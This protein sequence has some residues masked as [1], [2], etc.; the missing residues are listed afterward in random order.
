MNRDRQHDFDCVIVGASFAGLACATALARSGAKVAVLEKKSDV[1]IKLHT[2]G[3][4]VK[5][6][7]DKIALLDGLP[8]SYVRRVN[9]VRLYA[10]NLRSV[11]LTAPGYYFLATD[12]PAVLRWLAKQA[13]SAGAKLFCEHPFRG[14]TRLQNGFE[15]T[16]FGTTRFLVGA[17]GPRSHVAGALGLGRSTQYLFG[18]EYEF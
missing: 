15:I 17:D 16:D 1:G 18:V 14:A 6:V 11:D 7:I 2:T 13:E 5:D 8:Q 9:G 3:I 4:L 12:T 10:P